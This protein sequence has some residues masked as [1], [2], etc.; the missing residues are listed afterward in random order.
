MQLRCAGHESRVPI[1]LSRLQVHQREPIVS[2]GTRS[3]ADLAATCDRHGA[4]RR[5]FRRTRTSGEH[6]GTPQSRRAPACDLRVEEPNLLKL[7]ASDGH[8]ATSR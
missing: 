1:G 8:V 3:T 6:A 2:G 7:V 5:G 4:T